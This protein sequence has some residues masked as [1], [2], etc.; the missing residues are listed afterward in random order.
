V[1]AV[2]SLHF[3]FGGSI[4]SVLLGYCF[5]GCF[6]LLSKTSNLV[7]LL[8]NLLASLFDE[9]IKVGSLCLVG[10]LNVVV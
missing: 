8:L 3:G 1:D 6:E 2:A 9:V 4:I 7:I 10:F 5:L